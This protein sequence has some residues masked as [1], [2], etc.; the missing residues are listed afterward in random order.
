MPL[1]LVCVGKLSQAHFQAAAADYLKRICRH[2]PVETVEIADEPLGRRSDEE[3]RRREGVRI[4]KAI[5]ENFY[6]VLTDRQGRA[7]TSERFAARLDKLLVGGRSN[8][9]FVIGGTVGVSDEIRARADETVSFSQ[10][11]MAHQLARVVLLEQIYRALSIIRGEKYH[12]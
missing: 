12:R 10:M 5:P 2:L 6:V 8:I 3:V 7:L 4:L 1:R 9:A 11:T